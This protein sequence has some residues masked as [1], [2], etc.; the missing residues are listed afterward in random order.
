MSQHDHDFDE[1]LRRALHEA[2]NSVEPADDGLERIRA[3]LT[4][5]H[6]A[7]VAWVMTVFSAA[8]RWMLNAG[9]SAAARVQAVSGT[10][11][12]RL[13]PPPGGPQRWRSPAVLAAAAVVAVTAGV[14]AVT[15][16]PQQ[17]VSGTAA[18][19]RSIGAGHGGSPGHRGGGQAEGGSGVVPLPG[20]SSS[21]APRPSHRHHPAS[22]SP[23]VTP[24]P[25][26]DPAPTGSPSPSPSVS[27]SPTPTP[28]P[29]PSVS[30]SPTPSPGTGSASCPSPTPSTG[31]TTDPGSG[32]TPTPD[33]ASQ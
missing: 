30:P 22:P 4:R 16:L 18:L 25:T 6:P 24:S 28:C 21:A 23:G 15:P 7:P 12:A 27:P 26:P 14:L 5:P 33:P 20:T 1:F 31:A 10:V 17:A 11:S 8:W 3:R 9:R 19:F 29:S 2:A 13:R 32:S